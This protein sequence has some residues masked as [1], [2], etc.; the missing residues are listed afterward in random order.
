[1]TTPQ[2]QIL[3]A[4]G[5]LVELAQPDAKGAAQLLADSIRT[6]LSTPSPTGD[7]GEPVAWRYRIE[8][9]SD[10]LICQLPLPKASFSFDWQPLYATPPTG[11][12]ALD[13][14]WV[15]VDERMPGLGPNA[16]VLATYCTN[17][18]KP[19]VVRAYFAPKHTIETSGEMDEFADYSEEDDCYYTPEGWYECNAHEETNWLIDEVVTHWMPLPAPPAIASTE[20][21]KHV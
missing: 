7:A 5:G 10:W 3:F 8:G 16:F 20:G 19:R 4:V 2:D 12:D 21:E 9:G 18:G 11:A 6:A 13:A 1:M 17:Y 14:R 15:S